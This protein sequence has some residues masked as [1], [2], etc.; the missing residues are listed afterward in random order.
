MRFIY[1]LL[2]QW[3]KFRKPKD[4]Y[5]KTERFNYDKDGDKP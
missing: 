3:D 5:I 1:W 2:S 4:Q